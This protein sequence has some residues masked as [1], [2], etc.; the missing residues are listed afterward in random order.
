MLHQFDGL[1]ACSQRACITAG[2][3]FDAVS[4]RPKCLVK[5]TKYYFNHK[6]Y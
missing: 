4:A 1:P 5:E 3:E 2:V 6:A